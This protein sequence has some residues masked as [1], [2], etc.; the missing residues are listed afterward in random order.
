[1]DPLIIMLA[2]CV[3]LI[4]VAIVRRLTVSAGE[5]GEN[6]VASK[7]RWLPRNQY[8]VINDLVFTKGNG[9]TTQIDHVVVSPYGI[10]VIETKNIYGYIHGSDNSKLWRSC[11]RN[12]DLAFDN[13]ILQNKAHIMAL[14]EKLK[15]RDDRF[16]SIIAFSTNANLQVSVSDTYIIYWSQ[17]RKLIRHFKE[18]IMSKEEAKKIYSV[19]KSINITDKKSRKEHAVRAS[20][21]KINYEIRSQKAVEEGRCPKCGGHLVLR[22]GKHG[23]FYGCSNYPNCIYTHPAY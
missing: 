21:N 18:P 7:L 6:A 11:W 9:N 23:A 19:I 8:F 15:L 17:V 13:P 10:F 14:A 12:R 1:M 2:I 5:V 20:I 4:I 16:V 22:N 3:V